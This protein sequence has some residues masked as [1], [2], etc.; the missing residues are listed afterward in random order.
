MSNGPAVDA[1]VDGVTRVSSAVAEAAGSLRAATG[2]A[3]P[4]LVPLTTAGGRVWSPRVEQLM[5]GSLDDVRLTVVAQY[6]PR[7]LQIDKQ[8]PWQQPARL[9]SAEGARDGQHGE[10]EITAAPTRSTSIE[11]LFDGYEAHRSV[12]PEIDKLERLS[13]IRDP[14]SPDEARR[15][16]HHCVVTWGAAGTRPCRCV[17]ETLTTRVTMFAPDGAPLRA[18]CTV[19]LKE[20]NVLAKSR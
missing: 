18:T 2:D 15:R 9:P 1:I 16:P 17:I 7:E 12:Q 19:K 4:R 10:V 13:S 8:I 5:I 14:G 11:L 20:V 6:N 3:V